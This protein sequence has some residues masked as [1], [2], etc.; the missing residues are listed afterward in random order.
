MRTKIISLNERKKY[1]DNIKINEY[2]VYTFNPLPAEWVI[3]FIL[4]QAI[5]YQ[6]HIN[7]R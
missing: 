7:N 4:K 6:K 2:I 3:L 5:S 1:P